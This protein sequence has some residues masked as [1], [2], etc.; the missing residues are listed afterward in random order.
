MA[1]GGAGSK[2]VVNVPLPCELLPDSRIRDKVSFDQRMTAMCVEVKDVEAPKRCLVNCQQH[3]YFL[4][5]LMFRFARILHDKSKP[6]LVAC[7]IVE[8]CI[9]VHDSIRGSIS[10]GRVF[11]LFLP[12][13]CKNWFR[14]VVKDVAMIN[15]GYHGLN[16]VFA[17]DFDFDTIDRLST[18]NVEED[19]HFEDDDG[20]WGADADGR[21]PKG[22]NNRE[23]RKTTRTLVENFCAFDLVRGMGLQNMK[24][25]QIKVTDSVAEKVSLRRLED[26]DRHLELYFT[27]MFLEWNENNHSRLPPDIR[28]NDESEA[29]DHRLRILSPQYLFR[30]HRRTWQR[31]EIRRLARSLQID[32]V[33]NEVDDAFLERAV[34]NVRWPEKETTHVFVKHALQMLTDRIL[35]DACKVVDLGHFVAWKLERYMLEPLYFVDHLFPSLDKNETM[36]PLIAEIRGMSPEEITQ[37]AIN[38]LDELGNLYVQRSTC[39]SG[40]SESR[41]TQYEAKN[42]AIVYLRE[43]LDLMGRDNETYADEEKCRAYFSLYEEA[44]RRGSLEMSNVLKTSYRDAENWFEPENGFTNCCL[45]AARATSTTGHRVPFVYSSLADIPFG[46]QVLFGFLRIVCN[47]TGVNHTLGDLT[48]ILLSA[49]NQMKPHRMMSLHAILLGPPGGGKSRL[50]NVAKAIVGSKYVNMVT[51]RTAKSNLVAGAGDKYDMSKKMRFMSEFVPS[52]GGSDKNNPLASESSP[53][54]T[55]LK[56]E[57]DTGITRSERVEK[58]V[59]VNTGRS[60]HRTV[61]EDCICDNANVFAMNEMDFCRSLDSRFVTFEIPL[62]SSVAVPKW[63]DAF[64]EKLE[65]YKIHQFFGAL[66]HLVMEHSRLNELDLFPRRSP[67]EDPTD[68]RPYVLTWDRLSDVC[69]EMGVLYGLKHNIRIR[70]RCFAIGKLIAEIFAVFTVYGCPPQP[71]CEKVG[72]RRGDE[73]SAAYN[74]RVIAE[75]ARWLGT[76]SQKHLH[77]EVVAE[78]ALDPADL[79]F[80]FS[81]VFQ[82]IQKERCVLDGLVAHLIDPKNACKS[83][84]GDDAWYFVLPNIDSMCRTLE[85]KTRMSFKTIADTLRGLEALKNDGHPVLRQVKDVGSFSFLVKPDNTPANA[86][87]IYAPYASTLYVAEYENRVREIAGEVQRRMADGMHSVGS[88]YKSCYVK[89]FVD[90]K[91][92]RD[93]HFLRYLR[94]KEHHMIESQRLSATEE[95]FLEAP[96][97]HDPTDP[98]LED[99]KYEV[100]V[101]RDFFESRLVVL[102]NILVDDLRSGQASVRDDGYV[103]VAFQSK[104]DRFQFECLKDRCVDGNALS[105]REEQVAERPTLLRVLIRSTSVANATLMIFHPILDGRASIEKLRTDVWSGWRDVQFDNDVIPLS[106]A[107]EI[108]DGVDGLIERDTSITWMRLKKMPCIKLSLDE[109]FIFVNIM[110]LNRVRPLKSVSSRQS[111]MRSIMERTLFCN[112]TERKSIVY[113]DKNECERKREEGGKPS[114]DDD[115]PFLTF[116]VLDVD[117]MKERNQLQDYSCK[118]PYKNQNVRN[119]TTDAI[120]GVRFR[121]DHHNETESDYLTLSEN[122]VSKRKA[123]IRV[124]ASGE[125]RQ[126]VNELADLEVNVKR[127]RYRNAMDLKIQKFA[128]LYRNFYRPLSCFSTLGKFPEA[129]T[130]DGANCWE[131]YVDELTDA[132]RRKRPSEAVDEMPL[133]KRKTLSMLARLKEREGV[134]L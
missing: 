122:H 77:D 121:G 117:E 14:N 109:K 8:P 17:V 52:G 20:R 118:N 132:G 110:L 103:Q 91:Y 25:K 97:Y 3:T 49:I 71:V 59:D 90:E 56:E 57:L 70:E 23:G 66:R 98:S 68:F 67:V 65:R 2:T 102:R 16:D 73:S 92:Q 111:V 108:E 83:L 18:E 114:K 86:Y 88:D 133:S 36:R 85:Q 131:S 34:L 106:T 115:N 84:D 78:S 35:L 26:L 134:D 27:Y 42:P 130:N 40:N 19:R 13:D 126:L 15:N 33:P 44:H 22:K 46:Y 72:E 6:Y 124:V 89:L 74:D 112:M 54:S 119:A 37:T 76:Q 95:Y 79:L 38:G 1:A 51:Y 99:G 125:E 30:S 45:N 100:T 101:H 9:L 87:L 93:L 62:S 128:S 41:R 69:Q 28:E 39:K 113:V 75:H 104:R 116:S 82:F 81:L 60:S 43:A 94:M 7:S 11:W 50:L 105:C 48:F 123:Y 63:H 4:L 53:E 61:L 58:V 96:K 29:W 129:L 24:R 10:C 120:D 55:A 5:Q 12:C 127:P 64:D 47:V 21:R 32:D 31:K 80:A 107:I